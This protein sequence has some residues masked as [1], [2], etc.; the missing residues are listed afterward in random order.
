MNGEEGAQR[1]DDAA[2]PSCVRC[3]ILQIVEI[4]V[5]R[6]VHLA[7]VTEHVPHQRVRPVADQRTA[8]AGAGVVEA[9]AGMSVVED[10]GDGVDAA[11]AQVAGMNRPRLRP[12]LY[13]LTVRE[14]ETVFCKVREDRWRAGFPERPLQA[15]PAVGLHEILEERHTS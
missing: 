12:D 14:S 13:H 2:L 9:A 10:Q 7:R 6:D 4:D 8:P 5:R 3:A 15:A 11:P 1:P